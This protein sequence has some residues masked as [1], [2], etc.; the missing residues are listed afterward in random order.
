MSSSP[1]STSQVRVVRRR[2]I[3]L[4]Q[5]GGGGSLGADPTAPD[6]SL[7][8]DRDDGALP[9][10]RE[11]DEP[12]PPSGWVMVG[13]GSEIPEAAA[14]FLDEDLA[15]NEIRTQAVAAGICGTP[16]GQHLCHVHRPNANGRTRVQVQP[17]APDESLR[18]QDGDGYNAEPNLD[19]L[20]VLVADSPENLEVVVQDAAWATLVQNLSPRDYCGVLQS[21]I[22]G[23]N[24][25]KVP[26]VARTLAATMR[27][28]FQCRH[29]LAA[30][31]T[32]P[33]YV[34]MEALRQTVPFVSDLTPSNRAAIERELSPKELVHFRTA[35]M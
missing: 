4:S 9:E 24:V 32:L 8:F 31:W 13:E 26:A 14:V 29:L 12:L 15:A 17:T 6:S 35:L 10:A 27:T 5:D 25:A 19:Q 16:V 11:V 30:L 3:P 22:S 21:A 20:S 34:R 1:E 28:R 23:G 18:F 2:R 7:D 33:D